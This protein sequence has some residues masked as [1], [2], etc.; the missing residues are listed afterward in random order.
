MSVIP[1]HF[2][3]WL[4]AARA[5]DAQAA[6]R[7]LDEWRPHLRALAQELLPHLLQPKGSASDLV[8]DTLLAALRHLGGFRGTTEGEFRAWL[9]S[10][11]RNEA[12]DCRRHYATGMR[13]VS[14]EV[15]LDGRGSSGD[16]IQP[17]DDGPSPSSEVMA[18]EGQERFQAML[19]TLAPNQ[20]Q[21]VELHIREGLTF[22]AISR[23]LGASEDDV[24]NE[25]NRAVRQL[26]RLLGDL[27]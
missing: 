13:R 1:G 19:D 20:R 22:A 14:A 21:I 27:R 16:G 3:Q 26:G 15:A 9:E 12:A 25:F 2:L 18:A 17:K 4:Q 6:G 11:L 10:I 8:Q 7:I 24:R 23:Q 5:G